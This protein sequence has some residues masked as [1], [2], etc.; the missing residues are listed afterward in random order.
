MSPASAKAKRRS[1]AISP[2]L[3]RADR[4]GQRIGKF[5]DGRDADVE[6]KPLDVLLDLGQRGV[7]RPP[8][9]HRL[10]AK[11]SA[12]TGGRLGADDALDLADQPPEALRLLIGALHAGLGP[13]HVA[14]GRRIR[15]HEPARGVGAVAGDDFVGIDRVALRL[16]HFLD[17]A[18]FDRRIAMKR[19]CAPPVGVRPRCAP[20]PAAT[21]WPAASR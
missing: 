3:D 5:V 8:D 6:T 16:R 21:H 18:D 12:G 9:F 20:P 15:Q 4:R 14:I 13:D 10:A 19:K 11:S 2:L 17:R 1:S 7:R